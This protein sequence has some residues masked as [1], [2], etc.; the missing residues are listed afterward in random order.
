MFQIR[1]WLV[2]PQAQQRDH[3]HRSQLHSLLV[4]DTGLFNI[5]DPWDSRMTFDDGVGHFSTENDRQP[6]AR[7]CI[8]ARAIART[9]HN[10]LAVGHHNDG[11]RD[12][13]SL[14]C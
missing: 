5:C 2:K 8:S 14:C 11:I 6:L 4:L 13:Q 1:N 9:K 12:I 3:C 7:F 10:V